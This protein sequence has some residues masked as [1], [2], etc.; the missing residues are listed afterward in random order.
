MNTENESD[1]SG[2][3]DGMENADVVEV[4]MRWKEEEGEMKNS[5]F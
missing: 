2:G 4:A 5:R 3:R 1:G